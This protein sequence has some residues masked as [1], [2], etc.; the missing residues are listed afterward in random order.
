MHRERELP[1]AR[2][3][4]HRS[5]I[6]ASRHLIDFPLLSFIIVAWDRIGRMFRAT[7]IAIAALLAVTITALPIVLDRCA[8]SCEAHRHSAAVT[9]P[10]H[11]ASATGAHVSS[12]PTPCGHDHSASAVPGRSSPAP[13][14]PPFPSTRR[15][16]APPAGG[17]PA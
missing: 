15:V 6:S 3:H 5:P 14:A 2:R 7:R 16:G 11:H 1:N 10:C 12:V 17:L 13:S 9:P 4:H 8:E